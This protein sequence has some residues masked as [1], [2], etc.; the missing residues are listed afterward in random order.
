MN[1][2]EDQ[3]SGHHLKRISESV[4]VAKVAPHQWGETVRPAST[5]INLIIKLQLISLGLSSKQK[6]I[7]TL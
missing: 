7:Q 4:L 6:S 3:C 2:S 1:N 5:S